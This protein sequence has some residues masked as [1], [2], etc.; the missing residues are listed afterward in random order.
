MQKLLWTG[1]SPTSAH[2]SVTGIPSDWV[3]HGLAGHNYIFIF[4]ENWSPVKNR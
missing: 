2:Q 4:G 3:F 1:W